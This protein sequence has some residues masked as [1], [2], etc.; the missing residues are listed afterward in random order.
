MGGPM[1]ESA[2]AAM[3]TTSASLVKARATAS[4]N[5]ATAAPLDPARMKAAAQPIQATRRAPAQSS[6][7]TARPTSAVRAD[8]MPK[9]SGIIRKSSRAEMP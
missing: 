9:A 1:I 3:A 2:R 6:A 8:P 4:G 5:S 7:P